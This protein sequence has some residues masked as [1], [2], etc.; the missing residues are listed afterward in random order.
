[1]L[2]TLIRTDQRLARHDG[3]EM[4]ALGDTVREAHARATAA[5][6]D[7]VRRAVGE[8]ARAA[9]RAHPDQA[10]W[11]LSEV[12]SG[13]RSQWPGD[14]FRHA[15]DVVAA[16]RPV[17]VLSPD[18][19]ARLLPPPD[20]TRVVDVVVVDDAG[21]VGPPE[22]AA[23]L[24]RGRQLLVAGDRRRLPP[25]TG[26][27]SAL[28]VVGALTGVHRLHRDQRAR[29]GRLLT[30]LL[31]RSPAGSRRPARPP[32]RPWNSSTSARARACR[33]RAR[34]SPSAPTPRCSGSSTW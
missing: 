18:A 12:H 16:L 6:R 29:D 20:A 8:R 28:E 1:M 27:P 17:W 4:V 24:A 15:G 34:T 31:A 19:V 3:A 21:Q 33:R 23:A 2:E 25:A 11:L 7:E 14:L 5:A 22:T 32:A 13:H 10:R 26:G 9:V 30:P